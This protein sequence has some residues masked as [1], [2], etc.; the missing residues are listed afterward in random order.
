[1]AA[2]SYQRFNCACMSSRGSA[3]GTVRAI[4]AIEAATLT[5]G[6][7]HRRVRSP[8]E[9]G[10]HQ[11]MPRITGYADAHRNNYRYPS[12]NNRLFQSMEETRGN[13]D[14]FFLMLYVFQQDR[15]LITG[16]SGGQTGRSDIVF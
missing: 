9:I 14:R 6:L 3:E 15:K 16:Q 12:K 5:L 1:M 8:Q 7:I 2:P 11:L 10:G 13:L 4:N